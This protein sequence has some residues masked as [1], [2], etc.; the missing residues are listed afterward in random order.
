MTSVAFLICTENNHLIQQSHLLGESIREFCGSL[1]DSPIYAFSPRR[2]L[3][4]DPHSRDFLK[5]LN[6]QLMDEVLNEE[7]HSSPQANKIFITDW[8]ERNLSEDILV[9]VD[10][11]SVFLN[12][13]INI[14]RLKNGIAACCAWAPGIASY[15]EADPADQIWQEAAKLCDIKLGEPTLR[16]LITQELMRPYFNTG[17]I[18]TRRLVGVFSLWLDTYKKIM[19]SPIIARLMQTNYQIESKYFQPEF[20]LEQFAFALAVMKSKADVETLDGHYNCPLHYRSS[21]NAALST[22]DLSEFIHVHYINYLYWPSFLSSFDPPFDSSTRQFQFLAS[23]T[24]IQPAQIAEWPPTF[25]D[26][27]GREMN[28]WREGLRLGSGQ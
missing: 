9:F 20:F 1:S 19:R 21:L 25:L 10:S 15:G 24:P 18:A 27:F 28:R 22:A 5:D 13:P 8:A 6:I 16:S 3:A 2:G 7:F 23:R 17:L 4:P 11:D 26:R 14:S 12:E